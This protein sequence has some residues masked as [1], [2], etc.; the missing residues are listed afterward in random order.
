M[1]FT[2]EELE[3]LARWAGNLEKAA[4]SRNNEP[5]PPSALE[6]LRTIYARVTQYP[7]PRPGGCSCHIRDMKARLWGWYVKDTQGKAVAAAAEVARL[8]SK[9]KTTKKKET[10]GSV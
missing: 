2:E 8:A 10:D 4:K 3:V 1:I 5:M 6:Q 9:K 7:A